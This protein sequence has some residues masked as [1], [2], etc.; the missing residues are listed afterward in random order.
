V[1]AGDEK[2]EDKIVVVVEG[3]LRS[4]S[5]SRRATTVEAPARKPEISDRGD[6]LSVKDK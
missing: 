5:H 4:R 3:T 6:Q 2:S 1:V